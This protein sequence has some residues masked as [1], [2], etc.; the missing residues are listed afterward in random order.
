MNEKITNEQDTFERERERERDERTRSSVV[1][2]V[3][4]EFDF[5]FELFLFNIDFFIGTTSIEHIVRIQLT[6]V[7]WTLTRHECDIEQI[8]HHVLIES[9][10]LGNNYSTTVH[11]IDD[12]IDW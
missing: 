7:R 4:F 12:R 6:F 5:I 2:V 9:I 1:L 10:Q 8:F 3:R 11:T